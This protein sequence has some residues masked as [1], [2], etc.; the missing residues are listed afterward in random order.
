MYLNTVVTHGAMRA[1][2]R[3]VEAAR[4][5]PFHAHLNVPYLHRLIERSPEIIFLVFIFLRCII[6]RQQTQITS[7]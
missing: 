3:S 5:T 2:G 6:Q 1:S 7:N 4:G